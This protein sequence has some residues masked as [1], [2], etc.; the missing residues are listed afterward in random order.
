M[1]ISAT[2]VAAVH[3]HAIEVER[4]R[5]GHESLGCLVL[6]GDHAIRY[7]RL[8]NAAA[9]AHFARLGN[10]RQLR[11]RNGLQLVLCHS[12]P[13]GTHEEPTAPDLDYTGHIGHDVLAI[14]SIANDQLRLWRVEP[15]GEIKFRVAA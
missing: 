3:D 6:D 2:V 10:E 9:R 7:V 8:R 4:D 13:A 5:P 11:R 15:L 14:Y 12:H 1:I